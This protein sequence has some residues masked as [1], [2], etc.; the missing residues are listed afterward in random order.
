MDQIATI[1]SK[2]Y[3]NFIMIRSKYHPNNRVGEIK[4]F[5]IIITFLQKQMKPGNKVL[6]NMMVIYLI[7][8][9]FFQEF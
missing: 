7:K 3:A 1:I 5:R 2:G 9:I 6:N 4:N 8:L